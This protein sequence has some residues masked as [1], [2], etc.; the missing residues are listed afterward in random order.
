MTDLPKGAVWVRLP[1]FIGDGIMMSQSLEPLRRTGIPLV[2]W[3][4]EQVVELYRGSNAFD[5]VQSDEPAG[6][7][8]GVLAGTLRRAQ[9]AA[10]IIFA[11]TLR[12]LLAGWLAGVPVRLGWEDGGGWLLATHHHPWWQTA[13]H[14]MD[15]YDGL[16]RLA[17]PQLPI[18]V[19]PRPFRPRPEAEAKVAELLGSLKLDSGFA[20]LALGGNEWNKRLEAGPW[21]GLIRKLEREGLPAILM[22][23][24]PEDQQ[25]A[26]TL[27]AES[28]WPVNLVGALGLAEAS[29]LLGQAR[30][31]V[32]NDS[33]MAHLAGAV[34]CPLVAVFGPTR[35]EWSAPRGPAVRV[36]QRKDLPCVP[37]AVHG[38]A[39][40]GHPCMREAP[41]DQIWLAL[42]EVLRPAP[43]LPGGGHG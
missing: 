6:R 21:I 39:V 14:H 29:A 7:K 33:A 25:L 38:C 2:A 31:M 3:G 26:E 24:G 40:P 42:Q 32:G 36:L 23:H 9:A 4:P 20:A 34:G 35:T 22:G 37:C 10:V 11:R 28:S 18:G 30:G 13:L 16:L 41:V 15:R 19:Q 27:L 8:I 17:Y 43:S 12:P 5:A 1:R